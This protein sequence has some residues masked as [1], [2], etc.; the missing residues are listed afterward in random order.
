MKKGDYLQVIL[1]S[2]KI[3]FAIKGEE[4]ISKLLDHPRGSM[5]ILWKLCCIIKH[6]AHIQDEI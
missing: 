3:A 4:W 5:P 2:E 1:R 6:F